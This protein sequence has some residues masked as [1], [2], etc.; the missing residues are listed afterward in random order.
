MNETIQNTEAAARVAR[1]AAHYK[2]N[3]TGLAA[4]IRDEH[5]TLKDL[6]GYAAFNGG[7]SA[8]LKAKNAAFYGFLKASGNVA[9]FSIFGTR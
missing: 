4:W 9:P 2:N 8:S 1:L 3:P 5:E 7:P 6:N